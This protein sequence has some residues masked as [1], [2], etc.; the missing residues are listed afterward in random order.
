MRTLFL[1][2]TCAFLSLQLS[3][4]PEHK[5]SV[6]AKMQGNYI[7]YDQAMGNA[8]GF[9][10]GVEIDL[11]LQSGFRPF[12]DFNC[13]FYP[14]NAL[15]TYVDGIEMEKKQTV[16][17]IFAGISY[18]VFRNFYI[19]LEAGPAFINSYVYP[20]IKPGINYYLDKKQRISVAL[21][22]THIFEADHSDDGSFGY[23]GLGL[24]FKVF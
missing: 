5:I 10:T 24:N 4:Q 17:L 19:T 23:A 1:F 18:P 15:A 2:L 21:S 22:L 7:L 11:N 12:L 9:G 13:D 6:Y 8:G 16:P 20:G 3:G 14:T